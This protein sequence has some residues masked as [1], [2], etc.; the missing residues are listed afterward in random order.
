LKPRVKVSKLKY[1]LKRGKD[2]THLRLFLDFEASYMCMEIIGLAQRPIIKPLGGDEN[3]LLHQHMY[4][5]LLPCEENLW[6]FFHKNSNP[7]LM[8]WF[9]SVRQAPIWHSPFDGLVH[10]SK[11]SLNL[12]LWHFFHT[13]HYMVF[14]NLDAD[15]WETN[16]KLQLPCDVLLVVKC[17]IS[18]DLTTLAFVLTFHSRVFSTLDMCLWLKSGMNVKS[19][20]YFKVLCL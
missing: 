17:N 14:I 13:F 1:P 16:C 12:T 4:I 11:T 5:V 20:T 2:H 8:G 18:L 15:L 19:Y 7:H 6:H 3:I 10:E 9:T